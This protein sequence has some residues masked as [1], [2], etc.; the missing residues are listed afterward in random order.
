MTGWKRR[1]WTL[2]L[3]VALQSAKAQEALV[4]F[5]SHGSVLAGGLP[6]TNHDVY[7]GNIFDGTQ[8]VF[9]FLDSHIA[10]NNRFLTLRLAPGLHTF[11]ASNGKR[12]EQRETLDVNLKADEHYFIRVQGESK[13]VPLVFTLQHGRLDLMP[14]PIA[15]E[16][17]L[18][19]RPL[20]DKALWRYTKARQST[21]VLNESHPPYC[22]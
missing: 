21:M 20:K 19:A 6:G 17:M 18:K 2:V 10:H 11:G 3:I 14:C 13:G 1:V 22:P 8:G 4:T 15:Q 12:P 9:S 7:N 5:Y 16:E